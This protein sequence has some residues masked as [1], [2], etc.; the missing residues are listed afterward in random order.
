MT[1]QLWRANAQAGPYT[2][3][4]SNETFSTTAADTFRASGEFDTPLFSGSYYAAVVHMESDTTYHYSS[5]VIS[6]PVPYGPAS[7]VAGATASTVVPPTSEGV[8]SFTST[9]FYSVRMLMTGEEDIDGDT[10][11][12]CEECDDL[13]S[14]LYPSGSEA[15]QCTDGIDNDCDG[16][17]DFYDLDCFI[18]LPP[19]V[20]GGGFL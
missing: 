4:D 16:Y 9:S 12:A 1:W 5:S 6:G 14:A 10:Y 2:L 3:I 8:V 13:S 11:F 19:I 17:S 15:N 7:L 20:I 18:I